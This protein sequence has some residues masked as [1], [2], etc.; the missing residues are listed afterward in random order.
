MVMCMFIEVKIEIISKPVEIIKST[1]HHI[2]SE[3]ND[4]R[5]PLKS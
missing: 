5:F 2:I 1:L 4:C 3:L